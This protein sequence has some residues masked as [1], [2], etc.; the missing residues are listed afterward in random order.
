[1]RS[2]GSEVVLGRVKFWCHVTFC[3]HVTFGWNVMFFLT[4]TFTMARSP[5]MLA[6]GVVVF[7]VTPVVKRSL[8]GVLVKWVAAAA[9]SDAVVGSGGIDPGSENVTE[10]WCSDLKAKYA[11][12]QK[13]KTFGSV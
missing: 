6:A 4:V 2:G 5:V 7:G 11:D 10:P 8:A 3:C 13:G 12:T 1:M 9:T